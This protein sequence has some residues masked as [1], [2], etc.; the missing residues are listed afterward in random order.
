M[1]RIKLDAILN[2]GRPTTTPQN[3]KFGIRDLR[4]AIGTAVESADAHDT[5]PRYA[6]RDV[7]TLIE[8]AG[9]LYQERHL[10]VVPHS[11]FH[12]VGA[13]PNDPIH[14]DLSHYDKYYE[15]FVADALLSTNPQIDCTQSLATQQEGLVRHLRSLGDS[16]ETLSSG[17]FAGCAF[18]ELRKPDFGE[19][20]AQQVGTVLRAG[21]GLEMHPPSEN[22]KPKALLL[23]NLC[24][25]LA[26]IGLTDPIATPS[27]CYKEHDR[28]FWLERLVNIALISTDAR[29]D[30]TRDLEKATEVVA[31]RMMD[32]KQYSFDT[33]NM[34]EKQTKEFLRNLITDTIKGQLA[35]DG[36]TFNAQQ[37]STLPVHT[38]EKGVRLS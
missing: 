3:V 18:T 27:T 16:L 17:I 12:N 21:H 13:F 38:S 28:G 1:D 22:K 8:D 5:H 24:G 34:D 31:L 20:L 2:P 25:A 29:I 19:Q 35:E 30:T 10:G 32:Q 26:T 15:A 7:T 23:A 11:R 33:A 36:L 4:G 6:R 37:T 14:H 9:L